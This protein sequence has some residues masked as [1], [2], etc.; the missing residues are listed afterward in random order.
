MSLVTLI[1][2]PT[3]SS[4]HSYSVPITPPI[5]VAYLA[6]SLERAGHRVAIVD[7][8][9]E[10]PLRRSDTCHSQLRAH[11]L[12]I[13]EIIERIDPG[14]DL[15]GVSAMFSQEWPHTEQLILAIRKRFPRTLIVVGGEHATAA[16]EQ[17]LATC[18]AV[19]LCAIGEGEE[20]I[21]ELAAMAERANSRRE[22][23]L[24][25]RDSRDGACGKGFPHE[26]QPVFP[27]EQPSLLAGK[28]STHEQLSV[29][30]HEQPIAGIAYR[31]NDGPVCS[32]RRERIRELN[33]MPRPAWRLVP[34]ETYLSH[35]FGHGVNLGRSMPILATRGCPYQC[36]FCSNPQM[37]TT[38][39]VARDPANVVD[40]IEDYVRQ[41]GAQNIDFYDLTAILRREWILE[42]CRELDRRQLNITYQLPSGTRSEALDLETLSWLYRTGCRNITYAPES[43][44]RRTLD[45]IHK[46]VQ[47]PRMRQ[48]IR[49]ARQAGIRLKCNLV[50]GFPGETRRD[51]WQTVAFAFRLAW[52][53]VDDVPLYL[54]SPYPGSEFHR[55]LQQRGII[56]QMD[57]DYYA[58]LG[59]FMDLSQSSRYCE[60]I[61]PRELNFYRSF[62]MAAAYAI[63]YLVRPWRIAR[64]ALNLWRDQGITVLEQRLC[65]AKKRWMNALPA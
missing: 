18:P 59:C 5:G 50:I 44:S 62:G 16:W 63:G 40:E 46:K 52:M 54:F 6:G 56:G 2:P 30:P 4:A 32:P 55:E 25:G 47:L 43:G 22:E 35:G 34:L 17:V 13:E 12:S 48:S 14:T 60:N 57:N 42:F 24:A 9:G 45:R 26:Q 10:A 37:W 39:Y 11:G 61:G 8:L 58:S 19:D 28:Q 53:G 23:G 3:V 64:T 65:D 15:I 7:A 33:Q 38:R 27:H 36:A 21:V 31:G 1:R 51:V 41:Y 49:A 29:F 20:T